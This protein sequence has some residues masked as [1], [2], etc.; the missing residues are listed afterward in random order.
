MAVNGA[1]IR[2]TIILLLG[3]F[4]SLFHIYF[5]GFTTMNAWT[6]RICHVTMAIILILLIK[7]LPRTAGKIVDFLMMAAVLATSAYLIANIDRLS[8]MMQFRPQQMDVVVCCIGVVL[9]IE[10]ARRINGLTMCILAVIFILY[11]LFGQHLPQ[12]FGHRG[13]SISRLAAYLYS[14]DGVFGTTINVSSTY[15]ILFV[16]FGA[17]LEGTG[18]G[19][20]FIEL[21][22][23]TFGHMRG[24]PAKAA[25]LA[26]AG[27]GT[28]SGSSAGN[29]VTTGAFTIPLMKKIGY[30]SEFAGAVE[31]VASTGGQIM[32]PI[33]GAGA[34]VMAETLGIPYATVAM[35]AIIPALLYFFIRLCHGGL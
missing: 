25:I 30:R 33:M 7:P 12:M 16:I 13:Y 26:S 22:T 21:A 6:F 17:V 23:A 19:K 5:L 8:M 28:I 10:T 20:L 4:C 32:P 27:M 9:V 31:A 18:G 1:T 14:I 2:N 15:M 35:S 11:S 34:F 24:G 3:F 29:V